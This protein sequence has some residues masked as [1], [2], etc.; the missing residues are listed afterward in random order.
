MGE[1]TGPVRIQNL[2]PMAMVAIAVRMKVLQRIP[3]D[4][5]TCVQMQTD[6]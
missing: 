6:S 3:N 5:A 4:S 2:L 1:V